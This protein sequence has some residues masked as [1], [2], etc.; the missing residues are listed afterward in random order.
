MWTGN[1]LVN[2]IFHN[3]KFNAHPPGFE[4]GT[5]ASKAYMISVSPRVQTPKL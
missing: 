5:E 1:I 4:P 3:L 2:D